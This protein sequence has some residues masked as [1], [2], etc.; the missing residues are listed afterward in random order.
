MW[1]WFCTIP[2]TLQFSTHVINPSYVLPAAIVFFIGFF[3]TVPVVSLGCIPAAAAH[4]M[5]GACDLV[6]QIHVMAAPAAVSRSR[7]SAAATRGSRAWPVNA[8]A[9]LAGAAIPGALLAPTLLMHGAA[10]RI[11]A[12]SGKSS[13]SC[14]QSLGARDD[15]RCGSCRSRA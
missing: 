11:G 13:C 14:G 5:M 1:G 3:E 9:F 10:N 4:F 12:L 15:A 6:M 7:G 8:A 2:W